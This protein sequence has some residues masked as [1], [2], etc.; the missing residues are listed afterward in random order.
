VDDEHV[1]QQPTRGVKANGAALASAF[2]ASEAHRGADAKENK[3]VLSEFFR[4]VSTDLKGAKTEAMYADDALRQRREQLVA[5]ANEQF[6]I[7]FGGTL[8]TQL[9]VER[10]NDAAKD[11]TNHL[12]K[13][14]RRVRVGVLRRACAWMCLHLQWCRRSRF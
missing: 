8:M 4:S 3:N 7:R 13:G 10:G 6:G 12:L 11:V 2:A 14:A 9:L 1:R 5:L